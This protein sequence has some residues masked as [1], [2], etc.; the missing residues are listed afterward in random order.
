MSRYTLEK[1]QDNLDKNIALRKKELS[2]IKS[3][4]KEGENSILSTNIR[5]GIVMLYSHWE[6]CIKFSA[7]EY[8]KYLNSMNLRLVDMRDNF[9]T[10]S[11]KSIIKDCSQS[12]K[13]E[14]YN[15]ITVELLTNNKTFKV[16]EKDKLIINTESN[17]SYIVLK[18]I[19]FSLGLSIEDY[20]L[21]ENLI[22]EKLLEKRNSIAHGE[23]LEFQSGKD[24]ERKKEI[25]ELFDEII[26]LMELFNDQILEQAVEKKYIQIKN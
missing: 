25:L 19:L 15:E 14:K 23:L 9:K 18:D 2:I 1:L 10:L 13:T 21:K 20:E 17:L 16:N 12:N 8:L 3:M 24:D 5:V 26:E 4:I 22:K 6:G 7:R 11:M